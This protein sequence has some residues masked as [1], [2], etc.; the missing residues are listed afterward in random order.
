MNLSNCYMKNILYSFAMCAFVSVSSTANASVT[1]WVVALDNALPG[2]VPNSLGKSL[3]NMEYAIR[4]LASEKR[5]CVLLYDTITFPLEDESGR[6]M[7]PETGAYQRV[8]SA[9]PRKED[10]LT[11]KPDEVQTSIW[12]IIKIGKDLYVPDR[13]GGAMITFRHNRCDRRRSGG[14]LCF[15][16]DRR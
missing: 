9:P 6:S 13:T 3:K 11:L 15:F 10:I 4:F 16:P 7:E 2:A 12:S 8:S 1:G 5:R 14:R